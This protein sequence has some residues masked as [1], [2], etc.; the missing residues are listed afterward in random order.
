M[1]KYFCDRCGKECAKLEEIKVP[2]EKTRFGFNVTLAQVCCECEKEYND[3]I[4]KL[5]DIRFVLFRNFMKG[6]DGK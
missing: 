5:T 4:D 3:I 2:S 1:T 6:G